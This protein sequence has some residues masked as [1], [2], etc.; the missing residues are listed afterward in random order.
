MSR[1][2]QIGKL[3]RHTGMPGDAHEREVFSIKSMRNWRLDDE[4]IFLVLEEEQHRRRNGNLFYKILIGELVYV[5][6]YRKS[7]FRRWEEVK[8]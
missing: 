2:L 6:M 5:L 8:E 1:E 4:D 7:S 3:Y